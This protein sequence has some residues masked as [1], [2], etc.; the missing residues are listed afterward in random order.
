[1]SRA[2]AVAAA[3][4]LAWVG[5]AVAAD[6]GVTRYEEA[7][8]RYLALVQE[9]GGG[10]TAGVWRAIA[11]AFAAVARETPTSARA[12][13]GLYMAGLCLE[14]AHGHSGEAGDEAGAVEAYDGLARSYPGSTLA[15][16]GLL[17]AGRLLEFGGDEGGARRYYERLLERHGSGDM[18]SAA[19]R[20]LA[21]L[22][23]RAEVLGVRF[24]SGPRYTRV[25]LD[26]SAAVPFQVRSLPADPGAGR[27][28]RVYLDLA[29]A[30]LSGA[31]APCA[32]V[33]DGV[34][35]QVRA[36]QN[37]PRTVRIVLDL[38]S[39][40]AFRAFPLDAPARLVVDVFPGAPS[41]DPVAN[42]IPGGAGEAGGRRLR[43]VLD[44]GHGGRDPG[45]IGV[46]GI[47]EKDVTLSIAREV[48]ARLREDGRWEVRLTR[49][50]DQTLAL[51]QRTA[52][53][54]AFGADLFISIH[55]N[56]SPSR[57]AGGVETYYLERATDRAARR[58]AARENGGGE[59]DEMEHILADVVLTAKVRE[60]RR[61]AEDLQA[62]LVGRLSQMKRGLRDLGVKR[63]PFYV[64][65]GAFMPAVLVETAFLTHPEEARLLGDSAFR[66]Q[67]AEAIAAGIETFQEGT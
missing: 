58:L 43:V 47:R 60:S 65:A 57:R 13:D 10:P 34:V 33:G 44:P 53:A 61:L 51:E 30:S 20:R 50:G 67:A 32:T 9:E 6:P 31:C 52:I 7:R 8:T 23:S 22:G 37:D 16:D 55:A 62:A 12:A 38:E 63:G 26:L 15:D 36:G 28:D 1:M 19:R 59:V 11:A 18:A 49:E 29:N 35:R 40:G 45:A 64:L 48:A 56:A 14:R 4:A 46:R 3:A 21:R 54:N 42:L 41:G 17:R 39:P 2:F 66:R 24:Y 27:R 5:V 25:V